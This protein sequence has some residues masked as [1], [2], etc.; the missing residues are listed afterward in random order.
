VISEWIFTFERFQMLNCYLRK[1]NRLAVINDL[2]IQ[3]EILA[4]F[5]EIHFSIAINYFCNNSIVKM[6]IK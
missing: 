1:H 6:R 4:F 3:I 2:I 5:H